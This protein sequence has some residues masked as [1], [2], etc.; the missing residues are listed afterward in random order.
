MAV[1]FL[2]GPSLWKKGTRA[3]RTETPMEMRYKLAQIFK[4]NGHI[5]FIMEAEDGL[6]SEDLVEKFDRMLHDRGVTDVVFFWPLGARMQTT[7]DEFI[8]LRDRMGNR[9]LPDIWVLH[10]RRVARIERGVFH[11]LE[12]GGRSRYL[13]A[14]AA[15]GVTPLAW[16]GQKE[17]RRLV[18]ELVEELD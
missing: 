17:L 6:P 11:V 8:L 10:D 15:L 3:S 9:S 4:E 14:V 16:S 5:T 13:E 7:F 1:V 12:S 2:L 18:Q